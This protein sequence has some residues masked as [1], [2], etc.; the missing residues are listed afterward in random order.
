MPVRYD[1]TKKLGKFVAEI[2]LQQCEDCPEREKCF[3]DYSGVCK[4]IEHV[5]KCFQNNT[6]C[7]S[8]AA[9]IELMKMMREK[10]IKGMM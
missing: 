8:S 5:M 4:T 9:T 10:Q 7:I 1:I 6:A 3:A 2:A